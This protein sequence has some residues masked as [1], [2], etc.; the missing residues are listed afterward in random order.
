MNESEYNRL[1]KW[2]DTLADAR[3]DSITLSIS[4]EK[5]NQADQYVKDLEQKL[6]EHQYREVDMSGVCMNCGATHPE[7][8]ECFKFWTM[9]YNEK[10]DQLAESEK[11][12]E[13]WISE[14]STYRAMHEKSEKKLAEALEVVRFMTTLDITIQVPGVGSVNLSEKAWHFLAKHEVRNENSK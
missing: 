14:C 5:F 1:S 13:T 6:A 10:L 8:K 9:K 4:R 12:K 11:Q 3:E 7:I 2:E